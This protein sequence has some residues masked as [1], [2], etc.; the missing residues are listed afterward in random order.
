MRLSERVA[1]A[2]SGTMVVLATCSAVVA[3]REH[4][5]AAMRECDIRL[6]AEL[7]ASIHAKRDAALAGT[8]EDACAELYWMWNPS[9]SSAS[10]DLLWRLVAAEREWARRDIIRHLRACTGRDLGDDARAW[11]LEYGSER[12][13]EMFQA[14]EDAVWV[15]LAR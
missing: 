10:K 2:V 13:R 8:I 4:D 12:I 9:G 14:E 3:L 7:I 15:P 5:K 11:I 6:A 1:I